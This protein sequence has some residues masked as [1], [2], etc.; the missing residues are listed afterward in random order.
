MIAEIARLRA[1]IAT[2]PPAAQQKWLDLLAEYEALA[3]Q[4]AWHTYQDALAAG[5]PVARGS[6][7]AAGRLT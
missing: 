5:R 1:S 3:V 4:L 6:D 7:Y 2:L